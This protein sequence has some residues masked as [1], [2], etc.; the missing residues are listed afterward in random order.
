[1]SPVIKGPHRKTTRTILEL[2]N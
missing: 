2:S 1:L